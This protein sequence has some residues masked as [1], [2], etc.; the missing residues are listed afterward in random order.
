MPS[1]CSYC[2]MEIHD[3][4]AIVGEKHFHLECLV[5]NNCKKSLQNVPFRMRENVLYCD[6][7]F[8]LVTAVRCAECN[9]LV[10]GKDRLEAMGQFYHP[11]H[12]VCF[13]C[14]SHLV[15][16]L[17]IKKLVSVNG[18]V[19]NH[20][21]C[22]TCATNINNTLC[23]K[24]NKPLNDAL[25]FDGENYMH[26]DCNSASSWPEGNAP[27]TSSSSST[28]SDEEQ[29]NST[30]HTTVVPNPIVQQQESEMKENLPV[31]YNG[32]SD[33]E[34]EPYIVSQ[35]PEKEQ[36]VENQTEKENRVGE[37]STSEVL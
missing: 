10:L 4:E 23:S 32:D 26:M 8:N 28:S 24:C 33:S 35:E 21:F 15:K 18:E 37:N 36:P 3:S 13:S 6:K 11:R 20:G 27:Y 31:P 16:P 14:K 22:V 17:F 7:C 29:E 34:E 5:C 1:K 25:I 9:G 2:T 19:V 30:S 12:L